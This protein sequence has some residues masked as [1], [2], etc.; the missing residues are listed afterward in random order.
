VHGPALSADAGTA[1]R[2][3]RELLESRTYVPQGDQVRMMPAVID[4]V[5]LTGAPKRLAL[6]SDAFSMIFE[7]LTNRLPA[8]ESQKEIAL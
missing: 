7:L 2:Q 6:G 1:A 4:S 3:S 8:P 5:D